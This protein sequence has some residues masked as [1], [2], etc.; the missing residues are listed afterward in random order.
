MSDEKQFLNE[1]EK[2]LKRQKADKN[3]RDLSMKWLTTSV[4]H[5]YSYQFDWLGRPIIQY[6]Q[7]IVAMQQLIFSVKPDLIIETGVARGGSLIFY[8]SLLELNMICGGSKHSKVVGIDIDIRD[9]NRK[10]I[11]CHP[12]AKRIHLIEGS[13]TSERVISQVTDL[14]ESAKSVMVCL[15][16]NHTHNHVL[17]ELKAYGHLVTKNSYLIVFDTLIEEMPT[18]TYSDRSWGRGNNPLTAIKQYLKE[19][20]GRVNFDTDFDIDGRLMVS[21]AGRGYLK[22]I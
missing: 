5:G 15:D 19:A 2:L 21:V 12:L 10:A 7:D 8:S 20:N 17:E 16:S 4:E 11:E 1:R 13:S 6:P 3:F 22:R 14:C 18:H 9:H